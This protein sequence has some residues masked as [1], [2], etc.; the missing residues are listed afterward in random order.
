MKEVEIGDRIYLL[1]VNI[2]DLAA[3][4]R[5][6]QLAATRITTAEVGKD[7]EITGLDRAK[8]GLT[9]PSSQQRFG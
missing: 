2:A 4:T 5:H 7:M 6:Q 3:N 1:E 9:W 8:H